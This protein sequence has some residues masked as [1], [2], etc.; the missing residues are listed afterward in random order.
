MN[1]SKTRLKI[2]DKVTFDTDQVET[3]K[4]ETNSTNKD[5][6]EYRKLVLAGANQ[7]GTVKLVTGELATIS[8]PDRWELPVPIKYLIVLPDV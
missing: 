4:L 1:K 6:Q 5:I 3:F 8:Y 7:V 2:G